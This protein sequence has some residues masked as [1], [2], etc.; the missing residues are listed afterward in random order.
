[1]HYF[2][3]SGTEEIKTTR[4]TCSKIQD[5]FHLEWK[6][7]ISYTISSVFCRLNIWSTKAVGLLVNAVITTTA[8][9]SRCASY[10]SHDSNISHQ[11]A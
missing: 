3:A 7:N 5:S 11:V 4:N 10:T 8:A 2:S 9:N 6:I 1:M